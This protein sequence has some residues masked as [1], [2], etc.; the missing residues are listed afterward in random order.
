M[1]SLEGDLE[2][3]QRL[4]RSAVLC[5]NRVSVLMMM[6]FHCCRLIGMGAW[7]CHVDHLNL[8]NNKVWTYAFLMIFDRMLL[9]SVADRAL[10]PGTDKVIF[11]GFDQTG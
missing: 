11:L 5:G 2:G 3:C 4:W 1:Y 9:Y 8:L 10:R 6:K 7:E